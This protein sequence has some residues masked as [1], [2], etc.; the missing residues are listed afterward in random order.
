V[1]SLCLGTAIVHGKTL[2]ICA[3]FT[4]SV[5]RVAIRLVIC[6]FAAIVGGHASVAAPPDAL[7]E[8][9]TTTSDGHSSVATEHTPGGNTKLTIRGDA[10]DGRRLLKAIFAGLST[11]DPAGSPFDLDLDIK[12]A[13]LEGFNGEALRDVEL[14]QS[15]QDGEIS[16]FALAAKL[17]KDARLSGEMRRRQDGRTFVYLETNDAGAFFRFTN[18]FR[19]MELGD[20]SIAIDV[21]SSANAEHEGLLNITHFAIVDEP[22]L[23]PLASWRG[24]KS[25]RNRGKRIEFS[26]LRLFIKSSPGHL[27]VDHGVM[28]GPVL[29]ATAEGSIDLKRDEVALRGVLIP[30]IAERFF[31]PPII[32]DPDPNAS[33][34]SSSY[35]LTGPLRAPRLIIN[36][37]GPL[38]PGVLRRL[39]ESSP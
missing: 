5:R 28:F 33:L 7:I 36:P 3:R 30:L 38:A 37:F 23:D 16:G 22:A 19:R 25:K 27:S 2:F 4:A 32:V 13:R 9:V 18:I 1:K 35:Q 20:T 31:R 29:G 26:R 14:R 34:I 24:G 10:Y 21:S 12:V 15:G 8:A 6:T 11:S 39:F 17:G